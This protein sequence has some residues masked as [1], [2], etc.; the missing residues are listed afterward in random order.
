MEAT[1][2]VTGGTGAAL[3]RVPDPFQNM[4]ELDRESWEHIL[5]GHPD[6]RGLR[7]ALENTVRNPGAVYLSTKSDEALLFHGYNLLA[8][9][10]RIIRVVITYESIADI[11]DVRQGGYSGIVNT[12]L[13]MRPSNEMSG[14]IG[15]EFYRRPPAQKR[16]ARR[17][18]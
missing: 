12:A 15:G 17:R 7:R 9:D 14:N 6:M 16:K 11:E 4:I 3:F 1:D 10:Q 18:R 8:P 2:Y 5:E 13:P